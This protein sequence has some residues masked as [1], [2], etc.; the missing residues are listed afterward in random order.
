[1][2]DCLVYRVAILCGRL[3]G[4]QGGHCVWMTVWYAGWPLCVD[5]C[6]VCRVAT[7][8]TRQSSTQNNKYQVSHNTF[9]S[10][11]DGHIAARNM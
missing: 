5:D 7:L 8:H 10:P 1:V 3:S 9:V 2:D 11:G 6:L 4:M